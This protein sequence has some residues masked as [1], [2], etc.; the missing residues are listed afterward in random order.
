[1]IN[2]WGMRFVSVAGTQAVCQLLNGVVAFMLVRMLPKDHYAWFTLTASMAAILNAIS[3]SGV[4]IAMMSLGGTVWQDRPKLSALIKAGLGMLVWLAA[5]GSVVVLPLLIWLLHRQGASWSVI[6]LLCGLN[7][8]PQWVATRSVILS[9][10]NRLHSRVWQMQ[11]VELTTAG[12]RFVL[13]TLPWLCG[14]TH[15]VWASSAIAASILAQ[16][17]LIRRQVGPVIDSQPSEALVRELTPKVQATVRHILPSTV[18]NCFQA[19]LAVWMLGILGGTA[20]VADIG[21]LNRISFVANLAGAPLAMLI[22]PAFA[23]CQDMARL[24]KM[25]IG[26]FAAYSLFFIGFAAV[27]WLQSPLILNLFGPKY[28]HLS[29]ELLLVAVGVGVT[30]LNGVCC[31]LNLSKGW[32][33]SLWMSIPISLL[34]QISTMLVFDM[35]SVSGAAWLTISLGTAYLAYSGT[36]SVYHLARRNTALV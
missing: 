27:C 32:V 22:A 18:F 28:S 15:V 20:E 14:M 26:V 21:A 8:I 2:K 19:H 5:A 10:V 23:R 31:A 29:A 7:I 33:R 3:D 17:L 6:C 9:I 13:T 30:A 4:G 24:R 25:F 16:G 11:Q 1:M 12:M 36:V 34:A 35:K